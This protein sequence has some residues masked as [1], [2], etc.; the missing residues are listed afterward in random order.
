MNKSY[1]SIWNEK[2]GTFVAVAETAMSRGKKSSGGAVCD[3]EG[4]QEALDSRDR[5]HIDA[6]PKVARRA[7]GVGA[8]V[9]LLFS[10]ANALAATPVNPAVTVCNSSTQGYSYTSASNTPIQAGC[11]TT[12]TG[13]NFTGVVMQAGSSNPNTYLTVGADELAVEL[14]LDELQLDVDGHLELER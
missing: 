4:D 10:G 1:R 12:V 11:D 7:A 13:A 6:S 3:P 14:D 5:E 9:A 8:S 2:V